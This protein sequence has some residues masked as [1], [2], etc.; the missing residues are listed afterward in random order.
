MA[1]NYI[2]DAVRAIIGAQ[3]SWAEAPHPVEPSEVRRFFQATIDQNPNYWDA[4]KAAHSRYGGPVAPPAFPVHAFRRSASESQDPLDQADDPDFDGVSR[5]MRPG[6]PKIP[7]SLGGILNGGYEYQFFSSA[8]IGER[9]RC[10]SAYRDIYQRE[11]KAGPMVLVIIEDEY[12]TSDGRPLL[13]SV[14]TMIMR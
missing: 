4:G 10:R 8:R 12:A 5:S 14:N 6:L 11:G 3:S 1:V 13:K 7:V 9:I 2:T